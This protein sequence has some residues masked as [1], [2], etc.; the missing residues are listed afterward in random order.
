MGFRQTLHEERDGYLLS[1]DPKLIDIEKVHGWISGESYW[2]NGRSREVMVRALDG[3]RPIGV[4][5]GVEQVA[6][7]RMVTDGATFAWLCDLFV[8]PSVR[9]LGIGTWLANSCV[10]WADAME[11]KRVLLVT[12]DTHEV[13][14]RVGFTPL[15]DGSRWLEIDPR[16]NRVSRSSENTASEN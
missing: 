5:R 10:A 13:Y 3:S 15:E 1:D 16:A 2:A 7:C 8:D 14:L 4:Y 6:V 9:T 11:I 12:R